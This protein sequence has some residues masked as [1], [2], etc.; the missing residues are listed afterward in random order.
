MRSPSRWFIVFGV[1][2]NH[3]LDTFVTLPLIEGRMLRRK[4]RVAAYRAYQ[5][6][7][8]LLV[9]LSPQRSDEKDA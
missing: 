2:F 5:Q 9:P 7:T 1:A 4:E 6:R 8:S 3:P